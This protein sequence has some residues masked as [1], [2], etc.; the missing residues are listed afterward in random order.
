MLFENSNNN[1]KQKQ[2]IY[3]A[4]NETSANNIAHQ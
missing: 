4:M 2:N 3:T 1:K